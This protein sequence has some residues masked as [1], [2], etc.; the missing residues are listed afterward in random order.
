MCPLPKCLIRF[1]EFGDQ[2]RQRRWRACF[3]DQFQKPAPQAM[4]GMF[5]VELGYQFL[6]VLAG[7]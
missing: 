4:I 5:G 6:D 7:V 2:Q 3:T 1:V